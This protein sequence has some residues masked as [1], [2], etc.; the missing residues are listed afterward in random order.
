MKKLLTSTLGAAV[1]AVGL[2]TQ[3]QPDNVYQNNKVIRQKVSFKNR[4]GITLSGDLYTPT[5]PASDKMPAI[6]ITGP[7]GAVKEQSSGLYAQNMAE[8]GFVTLAFD[9][10]Y[11]GE[12]GGEPRHV[13]SPDINTEDVSAAVDFLSI[14]PNIDP[15]KI[16]IIGICGFGGMGLNAAAMDTRI[17]ATA[18]ITMYDMSRVNANGYNDSMDVEARYQHRQAL[19]AQRTQD[20]KNG[21]YATAKGLPDKLSGQEPQF[22]KEYFDYYKTPRGFHERSVNSNGQWNTTSPLSF[23]N[24][25]ILAYS[26]EIKSAVLMVHGEKAHSRYFSEDAFKKLKGNNKELLIIPNTNHV[27]LYDQVNIIPFAKLTDFFTQSFNTKTDVKIEKAVPS[28]IFPR[29]NPVQTHFSGAAFLS[30]LANNKE[31][32]ISVYNVTFAPGV[33]NDWHK[34]AVGQILL[35]TVGTGY[36]QER[37]NPARYLNP[38]DRV[39]IPANVEHWHGAAP[40]C[41]FVHI[42]ITPKM[43]ENSVTWLAPV[44]DEE[45]KNATGGK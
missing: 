14:Q 23:I 39:E 29:G 7:F 24:M 37:G 21:T 4:Y 44:S 22:V 18:T 1:L 42:G 43:S 34:H 13:A 12:S 16:G 3:A 32:D 33:R 6:A 36:Y 41:E 40:G 30:I 19:N 38:G 35:C 25:P 11:T 26:N 2:F 31:C 9:P 5:Q 10:S 27:D 45:Y 15:D 8:R 17:K 28:S 20:A